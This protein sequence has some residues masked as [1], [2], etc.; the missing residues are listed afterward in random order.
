MAG[1]GLP[2]LV[3]HNWT[4]QHKLVYQVEGVLVAGQPCI[5]AGGKKTG[6]TS[7][8]VD[9][10]ISLI[11]ANR[12]WVSLRFRGPAKS[13]YFRA[14]AAQGLCRRQPAHSRCEGYQHRRHLQ[15]VLVNGYSAIEPSKRLGRA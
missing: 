10:G 6:K 7:L 14:K 13:Y 4:A 1:S 2:C 3:R 15:S 8:L 11:R 5:W 12:S 9:L